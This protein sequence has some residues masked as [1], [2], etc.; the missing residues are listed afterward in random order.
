MRY[1]KKW[2]ESNFGSPE[3]LQLFIQQR[4]GSVT[5]TDKKRME[6]WV[7]RDSLRL[8][9]Y[10]YFIQLLPFKQRLADSEG[11]DIRVVLRDICVVF[12]KPFGEINPDATVF[13]IKAALSSTVD[14]AMF[15]MANLVVYGFKWLTVVILLMRLVILGVA[16]FLLREMVIR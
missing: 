16:V 14:Q 8:K 5:D 4:D 6:K 2:W 11:Q 1:F 10:N 15:N 9:A 7:C 3:L 12:P 13:T